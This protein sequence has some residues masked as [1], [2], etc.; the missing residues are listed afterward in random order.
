MR[1]GNREVRGTW[2]AQSVKRHDLRVLGS[3]P[4]S[5]PLLSRESAFPSA[6]ALAIVLS[7]TVSLINKV[8]TRGRKGGDKCLF[9]GILS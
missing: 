5:G 1:T 3:S 2:V 8:L 7:L 6:S 4:T 9:S